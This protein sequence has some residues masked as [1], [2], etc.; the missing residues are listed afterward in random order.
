MPGPSFEDGNHLGHAFIYIYY[1]HTF[2][3]TGLRAGVGGIL[4]IEREEGEKEEEEEEEDDDDD[5]EE[6]GEG[7]YT[8]MYI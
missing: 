1:T 4:C 3:Y 7:L 5:E 8:C 2:A 6:E